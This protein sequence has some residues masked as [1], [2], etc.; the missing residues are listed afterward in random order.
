MTLGQATDLHRI[1][2]S[3]FVDLETTDI[4][5]FLGKFFSDLGLSG[6]PEFRA[7]SV[8]RGSEVWFW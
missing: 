2:R 4:Q 7:E 6:R 1:P 8:C 5:F 3:S